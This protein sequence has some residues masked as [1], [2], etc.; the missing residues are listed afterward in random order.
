MP[1]LNLELSDKEY[2]QL[3]Q[4]KLKLAAKLGKDLNWKEF[5]LA[6]IGE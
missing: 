6:L 5:I 1:N 4:K 3:L 2:E